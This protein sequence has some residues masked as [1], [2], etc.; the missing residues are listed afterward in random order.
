VAGKV[1][2]WV[3][4]IAAVAIVG[5]LGLVA[6]VGVGLYVVSRHM[7]TETMTAAEARAAFDA[8]RARFAGQTPLVELDSSGRVERVRPDRPAIESADRPTHLHL[9]AYSPDD[10]RIVR[11]RL[12]F[13]LLRTRAGRGTIDI[14][15]TR[16]DLEDLNLTVEDLERLGPALLVDHQAAGGQRVLVWSQ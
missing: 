12:P 2:T 1:P 4:V 11:F 10:A 14:D 3:W 8:E 6:M 15:G 13:W 7:G 16:L 9:I 5:V